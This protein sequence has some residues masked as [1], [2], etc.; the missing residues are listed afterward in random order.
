M[1]RMDRIIVGFLAAGLWMVA[2]TNLLST[3]P[4][5]ALSVRAAEI[6]GLESFVKKVVQRCKVN[7]QERVYF[8]QE[9]EREIEIRP[10]ESVETENKKPDVW[11][12]LPDNGDCLASAPM[13]QL[14]LIA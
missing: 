12:T 13:E 14:S 11:K 1:T 2:G 10:V 7:L 5:Y 4:S 3:K 9:A 8:L 6:V